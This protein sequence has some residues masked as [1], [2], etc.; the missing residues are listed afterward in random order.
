MPKN[1]VKNCSLHEKS[2]FSFFKC[3]EK[4]VFPKKLHWNMTFLVLSGK[5]IFLLLDI[6]LFFTTL[7]GKQKMIFLQKMH[8]IMIFLALSCKK[9][10]YF[11]F[12][13]Y[14]V[15]ITKNGRWSLS[16]KYIEIWC[17]RYVWSKWYFFSLQIWYYLRWLQRVTF[18]INIVLL[19][20]LIFFT[21]PSSFDFQLFFLVAAFCFIFHLFFFHFQV[22]FSLPAF[23]FTSNFFFFYF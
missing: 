15:K 21:S 11:C 20:Q 8:W 13:K 4:M 12:Q 9:R 10:W 23:L 17:F 7:D 6:I 3:S 2:F 5:M 19:L 18:Y 14:D 16:K 1:K 22:F